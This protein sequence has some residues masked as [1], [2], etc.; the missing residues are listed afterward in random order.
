MLEYRMLISEDQHNSQYIINGFAPGTITVNEH[1]YHDS[2]LLSAT[3]CVTPWRPRTLADLTA[4]DFAP[5][6]AW[7]PD[8]VLIGTGATFQRV[9]SDILSHFESQNMLVEP[10]ASAAACRSFMAVLAE[11]RHVVAAILIE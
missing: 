4:E 10:M 6:L 5:L 2:I 1:P 11:D 7:Q 3:N 8:L 9:S